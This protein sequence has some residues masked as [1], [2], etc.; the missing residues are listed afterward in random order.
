MSNIEN[1]ALNEYKIGIRINDV[2]INNLKY[3]DDPGCSDSEL[4]TAAVLKVKIANLRSGD[5]T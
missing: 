5:S 2:T 3:A 1:K 4:F